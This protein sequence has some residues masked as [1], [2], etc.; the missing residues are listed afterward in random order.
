LQAVTNDRNRP[1]GIAFRSMFDVPD[2]PRDTGATH[3]A[4]GMNDDA[5]L[6]VLYRGRNAIR[7]KD[8]SRASPFIAQE[9]MVQTVL[10]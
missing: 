2:A 6:K 1:D 3:V 5:L 4:H 7:K 8:F 10:N 9:K